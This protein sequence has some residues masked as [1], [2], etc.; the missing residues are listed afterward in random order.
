MRGNGGAA[1]LQ[2]LSLQAG[3]ATPIRS[4]VMSAIQRLQQMWLCKGWS[5]A[6]QGCSDLAAGGRS[7]GQAVVQHLL[8]C[9]CLLCTR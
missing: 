7:Q 1:C 9:I 3:H 8:D 2:E 6:G 5:L 4:A